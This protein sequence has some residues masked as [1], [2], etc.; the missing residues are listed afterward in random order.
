MCWGYYC[1]YIVRSLDH[2]DF[3]QFGFP[4][5]GIVFHS[6]LYDFYDRRF[7]F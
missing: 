3:Y 1:T 4:S 6:D 7:P 2:T 5:F